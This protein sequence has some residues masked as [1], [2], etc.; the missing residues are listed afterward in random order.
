MKQNNLSNP[1]NPNTSILFSNKSKVLMPT[2][3]LTNG[4]LFKVS[5]FLAFLLSRT[6]RSSDQ[7][8]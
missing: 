5:G 8:I 6:N 1:D 2:N 3:S 4:Q 7:G